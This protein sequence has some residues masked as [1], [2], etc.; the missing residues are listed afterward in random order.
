MKRYRERQGWNLDDEGVEHRIENI[1]I[2]IACK[3]RK[4]AD[5][6]RDKGIPRGDKVATW[7]PKVV[8]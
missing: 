7:R 2:K 3:D 6:Y 4:T 1:D 5:K 8:R